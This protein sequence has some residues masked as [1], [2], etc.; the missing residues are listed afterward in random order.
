MSKSEFL[1][2]LQT[3]RNLFFHRVQ[4]DHPGLDP[5]TVEAQLA[6]AAIWLTPSSVKGFSQNDFPELPSEVRNELNENVAR[7]VNISKQVPSTQPATAE[8]IHDAMQCFVRILNI[9]ETYFPSGGELRQIRDALEMIT[10]P[11][12]VLTWNFELGAD[13]TGDPAVWVWI[14]VDSETATSE[15]FT[16]LAND[17]QHRVRESLT[18]AGVMRWPYIRFRTASEQRALSD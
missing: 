6:R 10:F 16:Q 17:I 13:S 1:R 2:N 11:D 12:A 4:T 3:A 15:N 8:Q 7:F 14:F 5:E 18:T 9:L